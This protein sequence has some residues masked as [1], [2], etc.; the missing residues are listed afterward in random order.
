M[1][2]LP[3]VTEQA[4]ALLKILWPMI[5]VSCPF[6]LSLPSGEICGKGRISD[7]LLV[8]F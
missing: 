2:A 4:I 6:F 8:G 5:S 7:P 3:S 1:I